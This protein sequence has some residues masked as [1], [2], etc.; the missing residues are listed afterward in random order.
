MRVLVVGAGL[1][2]VAAARGLLAAGH[3]VTV[4][5]RAPALRESGC[6]IVL[7]SNG[8]TVLN[9]LGVRT[10]GAGERIDAIDVRSARGRPLMVVDTERLATRFGAPVLGI[11]RPVLLTRLAEGLPEEI[12]RFGARFT[13][14]HDD[15]RSVRIETEDGTQYS[16]DLLIGAD[17]VNSQV[18]TALFG[19]GSHARPTGSATWQGLIPAPFDLGS[20]SLLFLGRQGDVGLNPAGDGLV[21]WLIDL[22]RR[23]GDDSEGP[24]RALATLRRQYGSW[25]SPVRDLLAALSDK[26]LELFPHRRH[27]PPLRWWRGRSVLIGDAAHAMP[28]MLAQGAGQALEDVSALLPTLTD[29]PAYERSRRRQAMLASTVA[30]QG[31]AISGPRTLFQSEAA[32]RGATLLPQHLATWSFG[33]LMRGVSARL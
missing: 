6:A 15:G 29:L 30:T 13:R 25:A 21:Q 27:R 2:G 26:D 24:N 4:L 20:R 1:A 12:F 9:D 16:G 3:T 31:V 7:W 18:R 28:P 11:P 8:T 14:L 23:P 32:L 17:G 19:P 10:D 5:E 22:R 33:M